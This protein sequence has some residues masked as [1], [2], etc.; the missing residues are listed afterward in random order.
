MPKEKKQS[1]RERLIE[2]IMKNKY[3]D[4]DPKYDDSNIAFLQT[5]TIDELLA[6]SEEDDRYE[7]RDEENIDG[8]ISN[9]ESY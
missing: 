1:L 7:P 2:T 4:D 6:M 8:Y 5:L 3:G 9:N